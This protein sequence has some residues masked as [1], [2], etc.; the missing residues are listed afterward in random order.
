MVRTMQ[1]DLERGENWQWDTQLIRGV[2]DE[3]ARG[4]KRWHSLAPGR[5]YEKKKSSLWVYVSPS[6]SQLTTNSG[7]LM[8]IKWEIYFHKEVCFVHS[9]SLISFIE[10]CKSCMRLQHKLI[11]YKEE[12]IDYKRTLA[13][14][15]QPIIFHHFY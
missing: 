1:S 9:L 8:R 3:L 7:P 15:I 12:K 14:T 6:I 5:G 11:I 2:S 10:V 4:C 13:K